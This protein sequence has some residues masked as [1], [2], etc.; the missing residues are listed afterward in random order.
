M[1]SPSPPYPRGKTEINNMAVLG[2]DIIWIPGVLT[3]GIHL[4][5]E[6]LPVQFVVKTEFTP[7]KMKTEWWQ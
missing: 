4:N 3:L 5:V 1:G 2:K 7:L 6:K